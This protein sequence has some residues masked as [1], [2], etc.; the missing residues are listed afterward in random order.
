MI[1]ALN[2]VDYSRYAVTLYIRK[3]RLELLGSVNPNVSKIIVNDDKTKYYRKPRIAVM[4]LLIRMR[5]LFHRDTERLFQKQSQAI[6]ELRQKYEY[7]RFFK[8]AQDYDVA[9]SYIQGYTAQFAAD[10]INADRKIMFFHTSTDD[11][12]A[13]H[14]K[15]ME[16]YDRIVAVSNGSLSALKGFYPQHSAKMMC[17]ENCADAPGLRRLAEEYDPALPKRGLILC[18]CGRFAAVKGFD[19]AVK[20]ALRLKE[21]GMDFCWYFVGDGPERRHIEALVR[22]NALTENIVITGLLNNPYPYIKACDIYVQPSYEESFSLTLLEAQI[23]CRPSVST[24]TVG[25]RTLIRGGVNGVLTD[26]DDAALADTIIRL[27]QDKELRDKI[28]ENLSAVDYS[29]AELQYKQQ[30]NQL[31]QL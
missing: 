20:A 26:I 27:A 21:A 12:H 19:L 3:D 18:S 2:A 8:N 29:R 17:L 9:V 6:A 4:E 30:W 28:V 22:E 14:D 10:Y 1:S 24:V 31:L 5:R 25:G 13:L 16:K 15:V 23:I 7:E 11:H